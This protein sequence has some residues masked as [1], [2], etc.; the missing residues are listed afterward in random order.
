MPQKGR[1]P[2]EELEDLKSRTSHLISIAEKVEQVEEAEGNSSE[3]ESL[4]KLISELKGHDHKL[5][6]AMGS[7]EEHERE[8][9]LEIVSDIRDLDQRL[10]EA[11]EK[12]L[13][14]EM[15]SIGHE[16]RD[17]AGSYK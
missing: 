8:L 15:K 6:D 11:I 3:G 14:A 10:T 1:I 9:V 7:G 2:Q 16:L 13:E 4:K 12:A 5:L 17:I